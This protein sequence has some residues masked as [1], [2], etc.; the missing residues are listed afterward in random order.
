[1]C[2]DELDLSEEHRANMFSLPAEK[3]WQI[4][5]SKKMV[6]SSTGSVSALRKVNAPHDLL[7]SSEKLFI[8][9]KSAQKIRFGAND[10]YQESSF[11]SSRLHMDSRS[12]QMPTRLS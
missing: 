8:F 11:D 4:Y 9:N 5:Y 1:M 3:K 2:Q 6:R 7:I 10:A 12:N